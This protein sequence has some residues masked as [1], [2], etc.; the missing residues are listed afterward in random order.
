[1][2]FSAT[3]FSVILCSSL[4]PSL[5]IKNKSIPLLCYCSVFLWADVLSLLSCLCHSLWSPVVEKVSSHVWP[6]RFKKYIFG[7]SKHKLTPTFNA[8]VSKGYEHLVSYLIQHQAASHSKAEALWHIRSEHPQLQAFFRPL[9]FSLSL[10]LKSLLME[11][12]L[13]CQ[14]G[15]ACMMRISACLKCDASFGKKRGLS[16]F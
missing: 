13:P 8:G 15:F 5:T 2:I 9:S 1:M 4:S 12:A 16:L 7:L 14:E 11:K 3:K 6:A 10:T